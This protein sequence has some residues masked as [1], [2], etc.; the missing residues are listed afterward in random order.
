MNQIESSSRSKRPL[1]P[2]EKVGQIF[3]IADVL[4]NYHSMF[5]EGLGKRILKWSDTQ[6][7]GDYFT[8]MVSRTKI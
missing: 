6:L 4:L 1:I 2:P 3:S 8:E 7:L 5:L